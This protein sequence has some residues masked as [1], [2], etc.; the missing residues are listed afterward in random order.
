[1]M[2]VTTQNEACASRQTRPKRQPA[3][4]CFQAGQ[5]DVSWEKTTFINN[6]WNDFD[7]A[8]MVFAMGLQGNA[9]RREDPFGRKAL[10]RSFQ[11]FVEAP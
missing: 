11:E 8:Q 3:R 1:M 6:H 7:H 2:E 10:D 4:A 5:V 9:Q